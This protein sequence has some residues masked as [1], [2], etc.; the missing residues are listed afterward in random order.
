MVDFTEKTLDL[1]RFTDAELD[2]YIAIAELN[3]KEDCEQSL[4][5]FT[6]AAW[7]IV[8]PSPLTWNWHLS[9]ICGYLE[10]FRRGELPDKRIIFNIGPGLMKSLLVSVFF[11]AWCWIDDPGERF[12][13]V[14]C[15]DD[16]ASR[17]SLRMKQVITSE[18]Y[19]KH[20][21]LA[22]AKDQNEKTL[23]LNDKLG[24]RQSIGVTSRVTGKR[25]S[26]IL[27]D[28]LI[29]AKDAFSD[30]I[31]KSVNNAWDQAL[32]SRLN[33]P[34]HSGI[35]LIMQRLHEDDITGHLLRKVKS[36]W[37]HVCIPTVY[38]GFKTFDAG[39]D[40]GRPELNDP[41]T[42]KGELIFP[43][44]QPQSAVEEAKE[45]L[46]EYGFAGQHQ[47]R[48]VPLGGGIIKKHEW[49]RW[50]DDVVL[51]KAQHIFTSWDTAFGKNDQEDNAC[52][53]ATRWG[54]FWHKQRERYCVMLLG[55]WF[56]RI[57][58]TALREQFDLWDSKYSP[59]LHIIE[60]KSTGITLIG[61]LKDVATNAPVK[62]YCPGKG[63][64]KYS[65]AFSVT[66]IFQMGLVYVPPKSWAEEVIDYVAA[67][68]NGT[69]PSADLTDTV[70]A[71]LIYLRKG[72]W[73]ENHTD[74][75][76][77]TERKSEEQHE[78]ELAYERD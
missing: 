1:S 57:E 71:A 27:L 68:P 44:R 51:P 35:I 52:S 37:T 22:L 72:R 6:K 46:G 40:I 48:P 74:L 75:E 77:D 10:A 5:A 32:A 14:S 67:F 23:F 69:P 76:L 18:W 38:E 65:R 31:R 41:R 7:S 43:S 45:N 78:R 13:A 2:E 73:F 33:D 58:Y 30:V 20:W 50:P 15:A 19:Q 39:K 66:P 42:K 11:P 17:D 36:H 26:C 53:A 25:G 56:D 24:F 21:P 3:Q 55:R 62:S 70:T 29:D 4:E 60:A 12:L 54:V 16:L 64:D 34:V 59:D 8:D 47:Q 9:T 63:E 28:D 61:D 49:R